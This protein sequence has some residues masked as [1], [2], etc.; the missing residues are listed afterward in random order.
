MTQMN[1]PSSVLSAVAK[2]AA[3]EGRYALRTAQVVRKVR[4]LDPAEH[5]KVLEANRLAVRLAR[6]AQKA[7]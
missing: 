7:A 4:G 1:F 6:A 2:A 3:T 5:R